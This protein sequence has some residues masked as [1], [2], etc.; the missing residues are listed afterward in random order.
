M[1]ELDNTLHLLYQIFTQ[2]S[3]MSLRCLS[4]IITGITARLPELGERLRVLAENLCSMCFTAS[5][6]FILLLKQ[7]GTHQ[8]IKYCTFIGTCIP[9]FFFLIINLFKKF[10][11]CETY[12]LFEVSLSL[13]LNKSCFFLK[14]NLNY[15]YI[16][17]LFLN[18]LKP[19]HD[20]FQFSSHRG[21]KMTRN[22]PVL[23]EH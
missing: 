8:D 13:L 20:L 14:I 16:F 9:P 4:N 15:H 21:K 10:K 5:N 23:E 7:N 12:L 19:R 22:E 3:L 6:S 17:H 1:C 18:K 11:I 2:W